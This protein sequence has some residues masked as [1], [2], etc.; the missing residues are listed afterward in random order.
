MKKIKGLIQTPNIG[1]K[2]HLVVKYKYFFFFFHFHCIAF[3]KG[4]ISSMRLKGVNNVITFCTLSLPPCNCNLFAYVQHHL[5]LKMGQRKHKSMKKKQDNKGEKIFL[6]ALQHCVRT[7]NSGQGDGNDDKQKW[8]PTNKSAGYSI[9]ITVWTKIFTK[10][11]SR[12]VY[13]D[14]PS[15]APDFHSAAHRS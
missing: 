15:T 7:R 1:A 10:S 13:S 9:C 6:N 2:S 11:L 5:F 14:L 12:A 4:A 3:Y 8:I